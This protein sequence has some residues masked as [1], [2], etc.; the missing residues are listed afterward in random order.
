MNRKRQP[1]VH[2]TPSATRRVRVRYGRGPYL[3]EQ[4]NSQELCANAVPRRDA[5]HDARSWQVLVRAKRGA[6]SLLDL[7]SNT[8]GSQG[9]DLLI[10]GILVWHRSR[11]IGFAGDNGMRV[12]SLD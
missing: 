7:P 11:R 6:R 9:S 12:E 5:V 8:T 10:R 2:L 1:G 4:F 3:T